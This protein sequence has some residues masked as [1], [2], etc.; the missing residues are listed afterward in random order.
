MSALLKNPP[1]HPTTFHTHIGRIKNYYAL[2]VEIDRLRGEDGVVR[3][4]WA[5]EDF[6]DIYFEPIPD[7]LAEA[8]L[9]FEGERA[10]KAKGEDA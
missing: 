2:G 7:Y 10:A 4:Y 9:R 1:D 3:W 6:A 5:L 8:L